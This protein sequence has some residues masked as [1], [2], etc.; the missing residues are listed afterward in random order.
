M[1]LEELL[2][3]KTFLLDKPLDWTSFQLVNK[4]KYA[5]KN[6]YGIKKIKIGHAGTL[7]PKATG[8]LLVCVGKSTKQISSLQGQTK[9]YTGTIK[10]GATTPSYDTEMEETQQMDIPAFSI[11]TLTEAAQSFVGD[12]ILQYPPV[13]SAVKKDGKRLFDYARAQKEVEVPPRIVQ[14][15]SFD[16]TYVSMPY[17]GFKVVCGKGTYIRSLAFDLGKSLGVPAY[18]VSLRRTSIGSFEVSDANNQLLKPDFYLG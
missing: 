3:G 15:Y 11:Q 1:K 13:F 8:L 7:D 14:V 9:T 18:L 6:A 12:E 4:M 10:L 5:I 16:I 17:V 2:E